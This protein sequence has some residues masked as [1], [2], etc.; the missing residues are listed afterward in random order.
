MFQTPAGEAECDLPALSRPVPPQ[1][2]HGRPGAWLGGASGVTM[3]GG[4]RGASGTR[5]RGVSRGAAARH[6]HG[7]G[8]RV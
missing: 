8:R 6:R 4:R 5:Q 3:R 7:S 2:G 1:H